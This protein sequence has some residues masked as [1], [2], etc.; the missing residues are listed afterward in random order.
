MDQNTRY[1]VPSQGRL[2]NQQNNVTQAVDMSGSVDSEANEGATSPRQQSRRSAYDPSR[3]SQDGQQ[4][5][6][7]HDAMGAPQS[8][9]V[10]KK[11]H[12]RSKISNYQRKP[13][14]GM[15][16]EKNIDKLGKSPGS[17]RGHR[18]GR[19]SV[20]SGGGSSDRHSPFKKVRSDVNL[21]RADSPDV[22]TR[23]SRPRFDNLNREDNYA[24]DNL[25]R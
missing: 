21:D 23:L 14:G 22:G 11:P 20:V 25:M 13:V 17:L 3:Q 9:E 24:L 10:G 15:S 12:G 8:M 6:D 18:G 4:N 1:A 16:T 5:M 7:R 19:T 2:S